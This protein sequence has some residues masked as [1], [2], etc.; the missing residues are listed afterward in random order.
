MKLR[1]LEYLIASVAAGNFTR[2]AKSLRIST[3]TISRRVGRLE[4]ELGLAVF[5][6]GHGGVR[7]TKGGKAVLL[8]A[9]RAVA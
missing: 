9:R 3:S 4:D 1:D 7:L 5:E 8:H 2:A 6:R